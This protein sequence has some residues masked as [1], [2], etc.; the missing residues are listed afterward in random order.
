MAFI[1]EVVPEKDYDFFISMGLKNCWGNDTLTLSKGSTMW[2]ADRKR[3]AY[4]VYI[5]GGHDEMPFF[6]DFWWNGNVIRMETVCGG[7]GNYKTGVDI[8]W[9]INKIPVPK[10]I[11]NFK[12]EIVDM[13]KEAFKVNSDW[14]MKECLKSI[15]VNI[16]CEPT[17]S[18]D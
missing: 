15:T 11:W 6:H 10:K 7:K 13:I 5:G 1:Y 9:Y 14:C 18:E 17:I 8:V 4:I 12:D 3:N 2:C 16:Q